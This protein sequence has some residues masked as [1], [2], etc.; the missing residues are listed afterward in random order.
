MSMSS[1]VE[2]LWN[3]SFVLAFIANFMMMMAFYMLMPTLPFYLIESLGLVKSTV[4][5]VVSIYIISAVVFRPFSS[6][7]I[8]T[9]NRKPLYVFVYLLFTAV[10]GGY[11]VFTS[12]AL[13]LV[14]RIVQGAIW[15]IVIPLGNTLALDIM[16]ASRRG[17]GIGY[18]GMSSTLAMALGPWAGLALF[19]EIGFSGIV[20][21][22][23]TT[24][25]VGVLLALFIKAPHKPH[26]NAQPLSLDRFVLLKALPVATNVILACFS[27]GLVIAYAA[28]YGSELGVGSAGL[29]FIVMSGGVIV[30]R[31]VSGRYIDRGFFNQIS[32]VSLVMLAISFLLLGLLPNVWIYFSMA[33][34][35]GISCGMFFPTIQT[36][37][38][39]IAEHHQRGTATSTFFTAFDVGVGLGML[40]G[41]I[42]AEWQSLSFA[43][44][45]GAIANLLALAYY[46][47]FTYPKYKKRKV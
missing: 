45:I 36:M 44:I 37:V 1:G 3:S 16:P 34:I 24:S 28:L 2:K 27:Y 41:G 47:R 9:L 7:L 38:V 26:G 8:D 40:L 46:L 39:G 18:F 33:F 35:I 21:C 31:L 15:G 32:L 14:T 5:L 25:I 30:A 19:G 12:V 23:I 22:S 17:T 29:F 43:F 42:I 11:L 13:L 6:Y 10:F 20:A 4:G